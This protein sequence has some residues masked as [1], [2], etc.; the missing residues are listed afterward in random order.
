MTPR[1]QRLL[2]IA[3][4]LFSGLV[5]P[6]MSAPLNL[7]WLHPWALAPGFYVLCRLGAKRA[8]LAGWLMGIT[9]NLG[10]FYWVAETVSVFASLPYIVGLLALVLMAVFVS[11][12]SAF[13]GWGLGYIR[14][15]SGA[16]W[17]F[18]GAAWFVTCE[19]LN[20][21]LFPYYHGM[22][23]YRVPELF[24]VTSV[25]GIL[26]LS[27]QMIL[28]NLL[29]VAA[30]EQYQGI[31]RLGRR[32]WIASIAAVALMLVADLGISAWQE[33]RIQAAEADAESVRIAIV[34]PNLGVFE[35]RNLGVAGVAQRHAQQSSEAFAIDPEIDVF[36]WAESGLRATP[37]DPRN[38]AV[39]D[40]IGDVE[41]EVWTGAPGT[42]QV[43]GE[44]KR[45]NSAYVLHRD[46]TV[47]QR[48]DKIRLLAFG[49]YAPFADVL[50]FMSRLPGV[51]KFSA[52]KEVTLLDSET[53]AQGAFLICYEAILRE[54]A[55]T[56]L[57]NETNLIVNI[58]Y[59]AWFGDTSCPS[60]HLMM[61]AARSAELGIPMVR[62]ATTG[63][64]AFVDPRGVITLQSGAFEKQ[65][66]VADVRP[67][68]VPTFY[69]AVGDW[70]PWSATI[71]SLSLLLL[72]VI[73]ARREGRT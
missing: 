63:I 29:L 70:F 61:A 55:R 45:Y 13:F 56:N 51:G 9:A 49:E 28:C 2:A 21:Q 46:G 66:L 60:Q 24:L 72:G 36:V 41:R 68:K 53:P 27:F 32:A 54:F 17:P 65:T 15:V 18:A 22:S 52:G 8:F 33:R 10:I 37:T 30:A 35:R 44:N 59:D 57:P 58:T 34:Q 5:Q 14:S 43:G 62:A 20:P 7:Y 50:P 47:G 31:A 6:V 69:G 25:T 67:L 23:L 39:F 73:R 19:F 12:Y 1:R 48:Y 26:G 64:S 71:I 16:A 42:R 3:A 40:F 38:R 11:L 4:L